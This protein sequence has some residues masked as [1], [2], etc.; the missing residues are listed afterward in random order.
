MDENFHQREGGEIGK[1]FL[2]AI[3]SGYMVFPW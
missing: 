1:N 3:F 2:L